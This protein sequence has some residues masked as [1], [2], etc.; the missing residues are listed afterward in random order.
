MIFILHLSLIYPSVPVTAVSR[1]AANP[2]QSAPE[3]QMVCIG[4][5][6]QS[7]V[8]DEEFD[9][10]FGTDGDILWGFVLQ[11]INQDEWLS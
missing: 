5:G 8:S 3:I 10:L 6:R 11:K 7:A 4:I 1:P 9:L 2:H